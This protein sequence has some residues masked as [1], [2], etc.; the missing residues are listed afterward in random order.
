MIQYAWG[1][2][3]V[4]SI[5]DPNSKNLSL[6]DVVEQINIPTGVTFPAVA[7]VQ[8]D[9]VT[10]WYRSD[11][12][13]PERGTGRILVRYPNGESDEVSQYAV[14]LTS[15]FRLHAITR[16]AGLKLVEVGIY[17]LGIDVREDGQQQWRRVGDV[18]LNIELAADVIM[19]GAVPAATTI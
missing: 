5:T 12:A 14:D 11:P 1:I 3:C 8:L 10:T 19:A 16:I 15:M 17:F 9:V 13:T 6:I 18:P 4:R 2:A 7:P